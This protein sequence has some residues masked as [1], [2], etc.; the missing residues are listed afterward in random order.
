MHR[1]S[2]EFDQANL[3]QRG[4]RNLTA[5]DRIKR[6][7]GSA[8]QIDNVYSNLLEQT[9][10]IQ[11]EAHRN[12][13]MNNLVDQL[14][15]FRKMHAPG[16]IDLDQFGT[17]AR[18]GDKNTIAVYKDGKKELWK[19][20]DDIHASLKGMGELG[21]NWL[22][23]KAMVLSRFTRYMITHGP[24]FILRNIP[25]DTFERSV[26][27]KSGGKPWD[28]LKGYSQEE[29]SRYEVFG[30][31]QFGN[32][33][34]DK[35]VWD[36]E[37]KK[38]AQK[39]TK[40]PKNILMSP[41]RLKH[42]WEALSEKSEKLGRI[43][44]FRRAFDEGKKK[45]AADFPNLTPEEVEYE[46]SLYAAG[47]ARGLLDFAKAG[48]VMRYIN[49]AIP[50][51]NAGVRGIGKTI[52]SFKENPAGYTMK[53]A[54]HVLLPTMAVMAWNKR[55]DETWKEYLQLP[56]YRRDFFW[57]FKMG[58]F[59]LTIPKPHLLGVLSSGVERAIM[60][61]MG[62]KHTGEDY[63]DSLTNL[64]PVSSPAQATGPLKPLIEVGF[65]YDS[66]RHKP[67]IPDWEKNLDLDLRKGTQFASEAS[68]GMAAALRAAGME[69]DP[70]SLDFILQGM[71][72][73]GGIATGVG[74]ES[75]NPTTQALKST[76][77]VSETVGP[78]ARDVQWMFNWAKRRNENNNAD[79]KKLKE[80]RTNVFA[81]KDPSKRAALA[82]EL[83]EQATKLRK[84]YDK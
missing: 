68:K 32:Y 11:R 63:I 9:D 44:E 38:V 60:G 10:S 42:A 19:F 72:G 27:S 15:N 35:H 80:M 52:S 77:L 40:D 65:N 73:W 37:L 53:W 82:K 62:E 8:L 34:V 36:R 54:L 46:A 67:I 58:D 25:R 69:L 66:F 79:V 17:P 61:I 26:N 31:G 83:R 81:T 6:F 1:L 76:G 41:L 71:G 23:Q 14:R 13:V 28:I 4:G 55:D 57:N 74:R 18:T 12:V 2:S 45:I 75:A 30:G 3:Q 50:F 24:S 21:T 29:I 33:I 84:E 7:K 78:D 64:L 5:K 51:S 20:N 59:W 22:F 39:L 48:T 43:A 49:Q 47:E 16:L 56:A 70:R